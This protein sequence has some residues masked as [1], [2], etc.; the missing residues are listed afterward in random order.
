MAQGLAVI[1]LSLRA[2]CVALEGIW[3]EGPLSDFVDEN[4]TS[5][6]FDGL[7]SNGSAFVVRGTARRSGLWNWTCDS[8]RTDHVFRGAE[9]QLSYRRREGVSLSSDWESQVALTS[10]HNLD[11]QAPKAGA[12][13]FG[14]KDLQFA[15]AN[16]P[17]SWTLAMLRKIQNST[18]LPLYMNPKNLWRQNP[19]GVSELDSL[20]SSPEMWLSSPG[21]G[22]QAHMDHHVSSTMS[23]QVSGRK[24]WRLSQ[25]P[26]RG[27]VTHKSEYGDGAIYRR[28]NGWAPHYDHVLEEGDALFFP[29]GTIHETYNVGQSCAV[30]ITYQFSVPMAAR[31]YRSL[32]YRFRRCGDMRESWALMDR[33]AAFI[34]DALGTSGDGLTLSALLATFNNSDRASSLRDAF[35]FIDSDDDGTLTAKDVLEVKANLHRAAAANIRQQP[36]K[37]ALEL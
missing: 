16:S 36:H 17:Q 29:P 37:R 18:T 30:S 1:F 34:G 19:D 7:V 26:L 23:L 9:A 33:W 28:K 5:Q 8:I 6:Q 2:A 13:Y 27:S 25:I 11:E 14:I 20:H 35:V 4:L 21:A 24:R 22:A 32:L 31:Y 10:A 12:L 15:D 3:P